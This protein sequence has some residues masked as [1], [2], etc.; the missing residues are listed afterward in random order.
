MLYAA[1]S[2]PVYYSLYALNY[3][4]LCLTTYL[5]LTTVSGNALE[6]SC[7]IKFRQR[8]STRHPSPFIRVYPLKIFYHMDIMYS[9]RLTRIQNIIMHIKAQKEEV[10]DLLL[11]CQHKKKLHR[12]F[13][14]RFY[15]HFFLCTTWFQDQRNTESES[16]QFAYI[17]ILHTDYCQICDKQFNTDIIL[18]TVMGCCVLALLIYL[19]E[20]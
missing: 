18:T 4:C 15:R 14:A 9:L 8:N 5:I 20:T 3:L 13:E 10:E 6:S 7:F 11:L 19:H 1:N 16:V 12:M 17:G 2:I